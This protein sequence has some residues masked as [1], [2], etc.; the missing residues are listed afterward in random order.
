M[1]SLCKYIKYARSFTLL[2]CFQID[3]I[4]CNRNVETFKVPFRLKQNLITALKTDIING[5]VVHTYLA[6]LRGKLDGN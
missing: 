1:K 3:L 4:F 6:I 2:T 5:C